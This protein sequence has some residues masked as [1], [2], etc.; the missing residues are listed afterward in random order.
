MS[1]RKCKMASV[2]LILLNSAKCGTFIER[3]K[4]SGF[5]IEFTGDLLWFVT[6]IVGQSKWSYRQKSEFECEKFPLA[7]RFNPRWLSS[8][9]RVFRVLES[10]RVLF[11]RVTKSKP[12]L[13]FHH[14]IPVWQQWH[15]ATHVLFL[16]SCEQGHTLI[17][18]II[19]LSRTIETYSLRPEYQ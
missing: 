10:H 14:R 1:V 12:Y 15:F 17:V 2:I 16:S 11:I 19:L 7:E 18:I 13:I 3:W 6:Q 9:L 8:T 5:L 4:K